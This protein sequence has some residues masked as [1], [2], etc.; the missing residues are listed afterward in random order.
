V[1]QKR[2]VAPADAQRRHVELHHLEPVVEVLAESTVLHA[3]LQVAVRGRHDPNVDLQ[4][5]IAADPLELSLL[6]ET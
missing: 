1:R 6:K 3:L 5:F 2:D 4:R